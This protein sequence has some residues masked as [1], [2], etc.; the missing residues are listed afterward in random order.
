[1]QHFNLSWQRVRLPLNHTFTIS[2]GSKYHAN[3]VILR[4]Q[5]DEITAYGEAAPNPRYNESPESVIG[6]FEKLELS[7]IINT[8]HVFDIRSVMEQVIGL[9]PDQHSAHAA[10]EMVL[11]DWIGKKLNLP[12]YRLWNAPA[13]VGPQSSVTLGL[14][15]MDELDEKLEEVQEYPILKIK[16]GSDSDCAII[17]EI[18]K[19]TDKTL[20]VDANE[21]WTDLDE[22]KEMLGFLADNGVEIIEQPMPASRFDDIKKLR[23]GSPLPIFADEGFT[24]RESL[25]AVVTAYHGINIK[26]MKIGGMTT[27]LRTITRARQYGL[28]I[29]I[30]CMLESS[31]ANT[32][33]AIVSLFADYADLDGSFLLA[34]DPFK[35]FTFN[36]NAFVTLN[37]EPGLGV[38]RVNRGET[39]LFNL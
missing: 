1:M 25:D 36:E 16:L 24:G 2:R 31:L 34:E 27:A 28:K 3:N 14:G 11:C 4:L 32:A 17:R 37:D 5:A 13:S 33:G 19:H 15:S 10:V 9:G 7:E 21:G 26:L 18:R 30:G 6:F 39:D 23:K 29:M 20:W 35:G 38:S 8:G 22:A 12:L